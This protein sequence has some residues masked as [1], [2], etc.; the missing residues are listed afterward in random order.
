M[1]LQRLKREQ[2]YMTIGMSRILTR[3]KRLG[4]ADYIARTAS[5][6]SSMTGLSDHMI[7]DMSLYWNNLGMVRH[8]RHIYLTELL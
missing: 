8:D 4:K 2:V 1:I 5:S 3:N 6:S 7:R